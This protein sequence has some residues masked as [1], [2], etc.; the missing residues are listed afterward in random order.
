MS[1]LSQSNPL[2]PLYNKRVR[3]LIS[4]FLVKAKI[5]KYVKQADLKLNV[6]EFTKMNCFAYVFL[7]KLM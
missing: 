6:E 1:L 5:F 3:S 7:V 4:S 2:V